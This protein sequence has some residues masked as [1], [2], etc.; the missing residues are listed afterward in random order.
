MD[1]VVWV[2]SI[3]LEKFM[4]NIQIL[5]FSTNT[6]PLNFQE[7]SDIRICDTL[8]KFLRDDSVISVKLYSAPYF[9]LFSNYLQKNILPTI[10]YI[11]IR[12]ML[13]KNKH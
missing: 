8:W 4:R 3:F 12:S 6:V 10:K 9:S 2:K 7:F 13:E 11:F 1:I 5:T